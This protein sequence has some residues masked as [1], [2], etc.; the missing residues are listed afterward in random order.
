MEKCSFFN[1]VAGDRKYKAEDWAD[2]FAAFIGNGIFPFPAVG[3]QAVANDTMGVIVGAGKA[4]I[5]GYYYRNTNDLIV[6]IGTADGVLSRIDRIVIRWD[7]TAREISIQ[8]KAG[9]PSETPSAVALQR[10]ADIYELA[11]ADV[12]VSAGATIITQANITDRRTDAAL[13]GLA[14]GFVEQIDATALFAQFT[15]QFNTWFSGIQETLGEDVA[16]NLLNLINE[17]QGDVD[18]LSALVATKAD[19]AVDISATLTLASWTGSEAPY[20]QAVTAAGVTATSKI[21]IGLRDTAT[22]AQ[23]EAALAA[24]LRATA[25]G[26]NSVTVRAIG[27]LPEVDLPILIRIM[28]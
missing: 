16:G 6:A 5:N 20:T 4:W 13:C 19:K 25:Q 11:I 17:M 1:S 10:D 23:Y 18:D 9:T 22:D 3:L 28:G 14:T 15:A 21:S 12:L 24:K 26:T 2:Y 27:T 7:L 8:V